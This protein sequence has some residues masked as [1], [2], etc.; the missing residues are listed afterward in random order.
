MSSSPQTSSG[1]LHHLVHPGMAWTQWN[2]GVRKKR[3]R[4]EDPHMACP[5]LLEAQRSGPRSSSPPGSTRQ[6]GKTHKQWWKEASSQAGVWTGYSWCS[7]HIQ[8]AA[9]MPGMFLGAVMSQVEETPGFCHLPETVYGER[10]SP[11]SHQHYLVS[12]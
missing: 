8:P 7:L 3:W 11:G 5:G 2:S 6:P 10:S 4:G 12:C 1:L 9:E